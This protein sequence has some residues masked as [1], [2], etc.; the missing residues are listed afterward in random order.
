MDTGRRLN[1]TYRI[2]PGRSLRMGYARTA[3]SGC[4][5]NTRS[6]SEDGQVSEPVSGREWGVQT[7]DNQS[8]GR[9]WN[10]AAKRRKRHI[11]FNRK[12]EVFPTREPKERKAFDHK[13]LEIRERMPNGN[14]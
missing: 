4:I 12:G 5:L 7:P 2:I 3:F 11:I 10:F 1:L 8:E 14:F 6:S 13:T 9:V